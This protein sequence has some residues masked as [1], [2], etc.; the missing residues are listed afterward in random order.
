MILPDTRV[1]VAIK[2]Q[3]VVQLGSDFTRLADASECFPGLYLAAGFVPSPCVLSYHALHSVLP[4]F[5]RLLQCQECSVVRVNFCCN[6][7]FIMFLA[8][9]LLLYYYL[10]IINCVCLSEIEVWCLFFGM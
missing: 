6:N 10:F 8:N 2:R 7:A 9:S 5:A 3:K 1:N 4:G